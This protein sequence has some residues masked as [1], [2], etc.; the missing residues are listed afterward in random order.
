MANTFKKEKILTTESNNPREL[1][2]MV[3]A[4]GAL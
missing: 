1:A 4:T 2:V 3:G